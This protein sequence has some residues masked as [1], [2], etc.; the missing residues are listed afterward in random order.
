MAP[1]T[2][3]PSGIPLGEGVFSGYGPIS[4]TAGG[5][6][7]SGIYVTTGPVSLRSTGGN[8]NMDTKLAEVLGNVTIRSDPGSV[9]V[10]QEI[11]NI[12][13]GSNITI[14]AGVDINLY[15]QIDALDDRTRYPLHQFPAVA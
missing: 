12:R 3:Q 14:T 13:S 11:A 10:D 15:R 1:V 2:L 8:V 5:D 9:N 7:S 4:V 6:L